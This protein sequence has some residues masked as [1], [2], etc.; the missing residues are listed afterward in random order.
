MCVCVTYHADLSGHQVAESVEPADVGLQ[1]AGLTLS[2]ETLMGQKRNKI[3][4]IMM[5]KSHH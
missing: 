1:V 5:S 2:E 3:N 4:N